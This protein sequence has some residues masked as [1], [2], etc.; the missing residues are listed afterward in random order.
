MSDTN[1]EVV[2]HMLDAFDRRE[3]GVFLAYI[4]P[5]ASFFAPTAIY[6]GHGDHLYRGHDGIHAYFHDVSRTWDELHIFPEEY[7]EGEEECVVAVTGAVS[8]RLKN[9][10]AIK[11]AAGWAF[12]F[13]DGKVVWA[14]VYTD[15][16]EALA[17]VGLE[18]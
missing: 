18:T 9:G 2:R 16:G 10:E 5:D 13:R 1:V 4:D 3:V 12:R 11:T 7:V 14:R 8:G 6:A 17:D 15:P